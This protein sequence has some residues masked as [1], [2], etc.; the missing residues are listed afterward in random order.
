MGQQGS[1][2]DDGEAAR[3][4]MQIDF[5]TCGDFVLQVFAKRTVFSIVATVAVLHLAA[6]ELWSSGGCKEDSGIDEDRQDPASCT[7][8]KDEM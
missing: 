7:R 6:A 2:A 3:Q 5:R 1:R 4:K 8:N